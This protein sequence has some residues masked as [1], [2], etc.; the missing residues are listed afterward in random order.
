MPTGKI[1][2]FDEGRGFGFITAEDGADVFLHVSALPPGIEAPRPGSRVE[3]DLAEGKRG[4]SAMRVQVLST[5][6]SVVKAHRKKPEDMVVIIE[7]V[8][9]L[10]DETSN[11]LRR[12]RY[13]DRR[14]A[15][16]VAQVL[17]AVAAD[18][19]A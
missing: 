15:G 11:A 5:P 9:K 13:P 3:Y 1:R 2:F 7:D 10:L 18:I 14:S 16:K 17:R 12:G 19:E 6:P 8:I 4:P